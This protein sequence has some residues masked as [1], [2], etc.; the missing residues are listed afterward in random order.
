MFTMSDLS[1]RSFLAQSAAFTGLAT[2]ASSGR[3]FAAPA[4]GGFRMGSQS[5]SFRMFK[6]E[7]SLRELK[8]LGLNQMEFCSVH[9][10][11][12]ATDANFETIKKTLADQ[13]IT[14]VSYGVEGFSADEAANRKK[15]EFA[16]AL[17]AE[18]LSADPTADSFDSL[19][20]LTE[21]FGIKIA[22]HNHGPKARYDKVEDTINAVKDH[23]P[24]IGACLDSGHCIRSGEKPH[25]SIEKLGDRLIS[26]HLKDWVLNGPEKI[27]G[28]GDL[29]LP[30]V[31]KVLKTLQFK[32]PL[33]LEYEL[34]PGN[35]APEMI[36]GLANWAKATA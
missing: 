16:K 18:I 21:E 5:Y 19:D 25:E 2:L 8:R 28:E 31:A 33:M 32:G 27:L 12:D 6:F 9:F 15:F 7:D 34:T 35:P 23:S 3:A 10:P 17:G 26:M 4:Y 29:D 22:I 20:K 1:R 30:A 11:P 14:A 24:M 13:G 36:Q